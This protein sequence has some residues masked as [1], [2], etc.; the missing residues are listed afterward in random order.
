MR[1]LPTPFITTISL[2]LKEKYVRQNLTLIRVRPRATKPGDHLLVQV[3]Q[4][5]GVLGSDVCGR[6]GAAGAGIS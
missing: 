2:L 3:Q 1:P 6:G 4:A 5:G